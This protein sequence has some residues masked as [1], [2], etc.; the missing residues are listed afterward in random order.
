MKSS[1]DLGRL[2]A[3]SWNGHKPHTGSFSYGALDIALH[4]AYDHGPFSCFL[5]F[6]AHRLSAAINF[7]LPGKVRF[8]QRICLPPLAREFRRSAKAH[9][10]RENADFSLEGHSM[11]S[12]VS[13]WC[14]Q[15]EGPCF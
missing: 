4:N 6:G 10:R 12:R 7:H 14:M 9:L 2:L 1:L 5:A 11:Q 8:Q 3:A 15:Q 13:S